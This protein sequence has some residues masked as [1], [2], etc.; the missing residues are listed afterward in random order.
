M[1]TQMLIKSR[2]YEQLY[3]HTMENYRAMKKE[4]HLQGTHG[5]ILQVKWKKLG[6]NENTL[7][8]PR[9]TNFKNT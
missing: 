8:D 4:L 3:F 7:Y 1:E 9:S 5:Y 2:T 6:T